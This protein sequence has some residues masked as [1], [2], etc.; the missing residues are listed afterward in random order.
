M[1]YV[2]DVTD[3]LNH[4]FDFSS[5]TKKDYNDCLVA[6]IQA[7]VKRCYGKVFTGISSGYDSAVLCHI[8]KQNKADFR[9][10]YVKANENEA[11]VNQ[12]RQ[13][14]NIINLNVDHK[15]CREEL[16]KIDDYQYEIEYNPP[17]P[18]QIWYNDFAA[19][20]TFAIAMEAKKAGYNTYLSTQGSDEILADYSLIPEQSYYKGHWPE[21]LKE[22]PNFKRSANISYINKEARV[23]KAAGIDA[24]YPFLDINFIQEYLYLAPELKNRNYKSVLYEYLTHYEIP[25]EQNVKHGFNV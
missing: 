17:R 12:R 11:I 16:K 20:A 15:A 10:Y 21:D 14:F 7:I 23:A 2:K 1:N 13:I 3:F 22:W 18:R 5:Q 24:R 8:L 4:K 9:C 25:F 19:T 6:L